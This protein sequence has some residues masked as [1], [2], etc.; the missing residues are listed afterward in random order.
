MKKYIEIKADTN[1][2]DYITKRSEIT[3]AEIELLKPLIEKIKNFKPYIGTKPDRWKY[4]HN[5]NFCSGDRLREDLGEKS[6]EEL[7][8]EDEALK[9]FNELIPCGEYGIHTIE[10]IKILEIFNEINLL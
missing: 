4:L 3:D 2:G 9:L 7:Y 8:G 10:S 5:H 6:P 1:D